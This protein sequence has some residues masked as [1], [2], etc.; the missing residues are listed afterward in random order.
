MLSQ[1][2]KQVEKFNCL[3]GYLLFNS[4]GGGTGSGFTALLLERLHND[5][6]K[7]LNLQ[8]SVYPAP[9]ISTA[10]VEP[11]NSV[12]TTHSTMDYANVTFMFDNEALYDIC[13]NSLKVDRPAY[14]NLNRVLAQVVA[15]VTASLRFQGSMNVD[16]NE[17]QT[18]LVPFPRIHFPLVAYAPLL[19]REKSMHETSSVRQI[20]ANCFEPYN[21]M[22]KCDP[23]KGKYMACCMLYRGDVVPKDINDTITIIKS[24]VLMSLQTCTHFNEHFN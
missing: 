20:T 22:M 12:L 9:Q 18:N 15:S 4:F 2:R 7:A 13:K 1:I 19:A 8:F 5:Y 21:C 6:A 11:Y 23:R 24:K 17:F 10:V 14:Q 16:L 3:Q